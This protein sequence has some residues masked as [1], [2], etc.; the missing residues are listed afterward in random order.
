MET[1]RPEPTPILK[2]L[3]T[4]WMFHLSLLIVIILSLVF[5]DRSDSR[6][7]VEPQVAQAEAQPS[8]DL[9]ARVDSYRPAPQP[10]HQPSPVADVASSEMGTS[11]KLALRA[12]KAVVP[13]KPV[14]E[15][16]PALQVTFYQASKTAAAELLRE[17]QSTSINGVASGGIIHKKKIQQLKEAREMKSVAASIFRKFDN[18][19]PIRMF[20]GQNGD[21]KNLGLAVRITALKEENGAQQLEVRS[22]FKMQGVDDEL[23]ASEMTVTPQGSAFL[24]SF[25][26]KDKTFSDEDKAVLESERVL[27]IYNQEDFWEGSNDLIMVIELVPAA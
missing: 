7:P 3:L 15:G 4:H 19:H 11:E 8:D 21:G 24:M 5:Y 12:A 26:P 17:A 9:P 10:A 20:K 13:A 22:S 27:K 23:F 14:A 1:Y 6:K 18:Q 16:K 25:L 2:K